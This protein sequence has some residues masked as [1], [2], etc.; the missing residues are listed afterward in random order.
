VKNQSR[1][2]S[3]QIEIFEQVTSLKDKAEL[4][5]TP[6]CCLHRDLTTAQAHLRYADQRG[7]FMRTVPTLATGILAIALSM[8]LT[9]TAQADDSIVDEVRVGLLNHEMTLL[10]DSSQEDGV[11]VNVEVLFDS[12]EWLGWIG[13]PRP[14]VGATIA[15]HDN[16][17]S[18]AYTGLVWDYNF[19]G[20]LFIEGAFGLALHDGDINKSLTQNELGCRWNFHESAS[21]GYNVNESNRVMLTAEHI[22]NASLC[23][24]NEGL[25]NVGVR[26]GYKF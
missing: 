14:H 11:D 6:R 7:A 15:T 17:T 26:Y 1:D 4:G 9:A 8:G 24:E 16:A 21:L 23:S 3:L 18:F 19:W 12:P 10:R 25:T 2:Y 22:S 13:S 5:A 20:P